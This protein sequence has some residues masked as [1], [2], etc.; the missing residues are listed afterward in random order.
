MK[1]HVPKAM[2]SQKSLQGQAQPP[3]NE[4]RNSGNISS[5]RKTVFN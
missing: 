5:G 4:D 3:N 2:T 1:F